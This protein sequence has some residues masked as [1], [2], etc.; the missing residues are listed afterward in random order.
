MSGVGRGKAQTPVPFPCA[1]M[2]D[3]GRKLNPVDND[4]SDQLPFNKLCSVTH[5]DLDTLFGG[6]CYRGYLEWIGINTRVLRMLLQGTDEQPVIGCAAGSGVWG[7]CDASARRRRTYGYHSATGVKN[8]HPS[9][10]AHGLTR[11]P[12]QRCPSGA[13]VGQLHQ[14]PH[15]CFHQPHR[16]Q[17]TQQRA[18][19]PI[20][21]EAASH[22][23]SSNTRRL[24]AQQPR[25]GGERLPNK[26]QG[27][28]SQTSN[29]GGGDLI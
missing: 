10:P 4:G 12:S 7:P 21:R 19:I 8:S 16:R 20:P 26:Q 25:R 15:R 6:A 28:R 22:T 27:G 14:H 23:A 2:V 24:S 3:G 13:H 18:K 11:T 1:I 5:S 17:A 29:K 9:D